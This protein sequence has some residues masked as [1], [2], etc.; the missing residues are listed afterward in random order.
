MVAVVEAVPTLVAV[1]AEVAVE[2]DTEAAAGMAGME[3]VISRESLGVVGEE[4]EWQVDRVDMRIADVG[5]LLCAVGTRTGH[6]DLCGT[7][8]ITVGVES[9]RE[10]AEIS[11]HGVVSMRIAT[12]ATRKAMMA[13][14]L[15]GRILRWE[16]G[17]RMTEARSTVAEE[18]KEWVEDRPLNTVPVTAIGMVQPACRL[19]RVLRLQVGASMLVVAQRIVD[20]ALA[21]A[22]QHLQVSPALMFCVVSKFCLCLTGASM[23]AR[24]DP[25]LFKGRVRTQLRA[26]DRRCHDAV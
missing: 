10:G 14:G 4:M 15:E 23:P 12:V 1:A 16:G 7:G 20:T 6:R 2:A 9:T 19:E 21:R 5:L 11:E 24:R 26:L 25:V 22:P 8:L 3:A 13:K 17:I 18:G